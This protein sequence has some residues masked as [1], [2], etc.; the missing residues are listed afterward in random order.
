MKPP[1]SVF[2]PSRNP[3][4]LCG[5]EASRLRGRLQEILS[6]L[7]E[8][9]GQL[10]DSLDWVVGGEAN[11]GVPEFESNQPV[12][13]SEIEDI[14]DEPEVVIDPEMEEEDEPEIPVLI[15]D[16]LKFGKISKHFTP[17]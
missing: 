7:Q 12:A 14:E 6:G 2:D 15:L 3:P 8:D 5:S 16:L 10:M 13:A 1:A 17:D 9:I 11:E 4:E